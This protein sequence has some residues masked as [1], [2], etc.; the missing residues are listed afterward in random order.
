MN[1]AEFVD[2]IKENFEYK[3]LKAK[4]NDSYVLAY[5]A[6]D[7]IWIVENGVIIPQR[8]NKDGTLLGTGIYN[9]GMI[10][11]I[12]ALNGENGI[13]TCRALKDST[14]MCVPT[15]D[16]IS[17]MKSNPDVNEYIV[18]FLCNRFRFM[19][20]LMEMNALHAVS[21]RVQFF[22]DLLLSFNDPS[23][24]NIEDKIISEFLGIH[25]ASVSRARS[26]IYKKEKQKL[27]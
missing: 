14:V 26:E 10:L 4:K 13:I 9:D 5:G 15:S 16:V 11:G 22:D 20:N 12:T 27:L 2:F 18:G 7:V 8:N 3:L 19:M 25:P 1:A 21:E 6:S 24:R 23:L 17:L